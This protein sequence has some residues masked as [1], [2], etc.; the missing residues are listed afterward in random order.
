MPV[1]PQDAAEK[2]YRRGVA[3]FQRGEWT[4][5]EAILRQALATWPAHVKAREMLAARLLQR[6][7]TGQALALLREG[8]RLMPREPRFAKLFARVQA[9]R[10]DVQAALSALVTSAPA[11]STDPEHHAFIAALLQRI[12]RHPEALQRYRQVLVQAPNHGI[13][14]MG[15]AISLEADGQPAEA[16]SAFRRAASS[17]HIKGAVRQYVDARVRALS[18]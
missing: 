1:T 5:V 7:D 6:A 2:L 3:A 16:L 14:W 4:A 8:L 13:W 9:E 11:V 15:L 17:S 10:G 12:G 18:G